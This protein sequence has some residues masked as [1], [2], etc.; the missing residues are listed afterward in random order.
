MAAGAQAGVTARTPRGVRTI[1]CPASVIQTRGAS[2]SWPSSRPLT[3]AGAAEYPV[4]P[5]D[6][7]GHRTHCVRDVHSVVSGSTGSGRSWLPDSWVRSWRPTGVMPLTQGHPAPGGQR[8]DAG[9]GLWPA[10]L[11][12]SCPPPLRGWGPRHASGALFA[13]LIA[14]DCRGGGL[15]SHPAAAAEV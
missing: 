11:S 1:C 10:N 2:C 3:Q 13:F 12:F 7:Q 14:H 4:R 5:S 8:Q 15:L 6:V 9:S